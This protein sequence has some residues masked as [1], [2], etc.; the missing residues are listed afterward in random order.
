VALA[1]SGRT[2]RAIATLGA[3]AER[4]PD[5]GYTFVVLGRIW[6]EAAGEG[7]PGIE[8]SKA[9]EA[10]E[11][12][13]AVHDSSEALTLLGRALL[14]ASEQKLAEQL[15]Q[16]ATEKLP[17][18]PLA[19]FYLAEA[20]ERNGRADRARRA[21]LDYRALRG[22][23][24]DPRQDLRICQRIADLSMTVADAPTAV[25]WYRRAVSAADPGVPLLLRLAEAQVMAGTL[26]EANDT[27]TQVL[28]REPGNRAARLLRARIR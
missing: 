17:A 6:L 14:M 11:K 16:R 18:D 5:Y 7:P 4:F 12:A 13:A 25:A 22:E 1:A 8:L 23:E 10:L 24:P 9:L 15:L 21:L 28:Q 20:A 26:A 2:E 3:A 19:F 27:L